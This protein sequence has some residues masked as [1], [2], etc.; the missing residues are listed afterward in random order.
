ML[1]DAIL[2]GISFFFLRLSVTLETMSCELRRNAI[3]VGLFPD[4]VKT[5]ENLCE[6]GDVKKL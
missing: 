6:T 5:N 1:E 3:I 4:S 2:E